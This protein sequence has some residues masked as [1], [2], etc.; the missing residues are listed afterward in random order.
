MLSPPLQHTMSEFLTPDNI[1]RLRR[2]AS[3]F[4]IYMTD[5]GGTTVHFH[6]LDKQGWRDFDV[7]RDIAM[8]RLAIELCSKTI[9]WVY[10]QPG[11]VCAQTFLGI[12]DS[13]IDRLA[14]LYQRWKRNGFPET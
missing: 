11:V 8:P 2:A 4:D 1:V 7:A 13:K 5:D 9:R 6:V 12:P 3:L 10:Y 14:Q